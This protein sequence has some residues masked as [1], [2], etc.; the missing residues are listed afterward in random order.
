MV[1]GA[2]QRGPAGAAAGRSRVWLLPGA[3]AAGCAEP[4]P[5]GSDEAV[6]L[7]LFVSALLWM[8]FA[9]TTVIHA[10]CLWRCTGSA[11]APFAPTTSQP[12]PPQIVAATGSGVA[13]FGLTKQGGLL[14][15][16]TSKRGQLGLGPGVTK[17]EQPQQL[18]LPAA[19]VQVSAGWGHAAA[20]LG[21]ALPLGHGTLQ[22]YAVCGTF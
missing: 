1:L 19:A 10:G 4:T 21:E 5:C 8:A 14:A 3:P 13:S 12:H 17:A 11:T 15:W 9:G 7:L 20:L 16:G 18:R 22:R 2:Q 6:C